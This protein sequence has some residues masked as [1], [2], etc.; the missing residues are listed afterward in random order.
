MDYLNFSSDTQQSNTSE[1]ELKIGK[2]KY[3]D[4]YLGI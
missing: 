3:F 4:P 1:R 2:L